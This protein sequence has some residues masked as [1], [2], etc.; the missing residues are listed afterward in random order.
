MDAGALTTD[1][2]G[3]FYLGEETD[4]KLLNI[5]RIK[6][7]NQFWQNSLKKRRA[8]CLNRIMSSSLESSISV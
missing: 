4:E 5:S 8:T 1:E 3:Y 7:L 2:G 6:S